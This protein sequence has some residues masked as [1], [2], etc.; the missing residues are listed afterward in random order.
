MMSVQKR[1]DTA[2]RDLRNAVRD[3]D[4]SRTIGHDEGFWH[5][6][7]AAERAECYLCN[8]NHPEADP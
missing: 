3:A 4:C 8:L 1:R 6:D 2:M 7:T 5:Y